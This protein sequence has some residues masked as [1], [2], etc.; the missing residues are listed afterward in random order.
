[1]I[2]KLERKTV[3][4]GIAIERNPL[5]LL[6]RVYPYLLP[7][8]SIA[9]PSCAHKPILRSEAPGHSACIGATREEHDRKKS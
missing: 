6:I 7:S 1:M 2:Q 4:L 5:D 9:E 8:K 3:P